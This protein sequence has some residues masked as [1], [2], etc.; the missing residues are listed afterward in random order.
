M[1]IVT[2]QGRNYIVKFRTLHKYYDVN[3]IDNYG[4]IHRT[5]WKEP[6]TVC[7]VKEFKRNITESF[8]QWTGSSWCRY[9]DNY[10]EKKGI[11]MALKK[12][13]DIS[14]ISE[15]DKKFITE[16]VL[17][18]KK[19]HFKAVRPFMKSID[20]KQFLKEIAFC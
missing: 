14:T 20:K 9:T 17:A 7:T 2:E 18:D 4:R 3:S 1:I 15:G 13:L 12:A 11:E 10:D 19:I 6:M 16:K 8:G 5:V